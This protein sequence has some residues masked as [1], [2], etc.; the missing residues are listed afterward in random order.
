MFWLP[1]LSVF[2]AVVSVREVV[3]VICEVFGII[4]SDIMIGQGGRDSGRL[5]TVRL[6]WIDYD[7]SCMLLFHPRDI[8]L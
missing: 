7:G 8:L 5:L 1:I 4:F 3:Q 6:S 2:S